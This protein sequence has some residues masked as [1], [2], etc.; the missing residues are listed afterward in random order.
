MKSIGFKER[1]DKGF[2]AIVKGLWQ[3]GTEV[4]IF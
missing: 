2:Y 3:Q 1:I 4:Y